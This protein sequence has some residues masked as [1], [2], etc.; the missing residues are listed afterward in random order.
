MYMLEVG[1][2]DGPAFTAADLVQ[3]DDLVTAPAFGLKGGGVAP[4]FA[5]LEL[6]DLVLALARVAGVL[7]ADDPGP[8]DADGGGLVA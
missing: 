5:A 6:H 7:P 2:V 1:W 3:P 8:N 4:W